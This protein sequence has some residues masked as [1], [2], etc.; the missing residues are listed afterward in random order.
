[1]NE[2][3]NDMIQTIN[4]LKQSIKSLFDD[5]FS[6]DIEKVLNE[7]NEQMDI[8]LSSIEEYKIHFESFKIPQELIDYCLNYGRDIIKPYY[9]R[10]ESLI[11]KETR[12]LTQ[13][14]VEKNSIEFEK[15]FNSYEILN[16]IDKVNS[17]VQMNIDDSFKDIDSYGV[18]NYPNILENEINRIESRN[19]RRLND[20]Q[21]EEDKIEEYREKIADRAI[22]EN[23]NKL[24]GL[25]K[26]TK[27]YIQNYEYFDIFSDNIKNFRK[28]L[29]LSYK[30][31]QQTIHDSFEE[32]IDMQELLNDKLE[33]L[34][35]LSLNYY[36]EIEYSFNSLKNYIQNSL[37]EIDIS[38]NECANITYETFAEKYDSLSKEANPIDKPYDEVIKNIPMKEFY[39]SNQF[40]EFITEATIKALVKKAKFKFQL[41]Y[42]GEEG[43]IKKPKILAIVNNEIKP[44]EIR[45]KVKETFGGCGEEYQKFDIL[46]INKLN[47]TIILTF[48]TESTLVNYTTITDFDKIN[49]QISRYKIEDSETNS[50]VDTLE[51]GLCIKECEDYNITIIDEPKW[52]N[53]DKVNR[54]EPKSLIY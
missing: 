34:Y 38:L 8:T 17:S 19:L 25:S 20:E 35:N 50:C 9:E 31:S 2:Q 10:I 18:K 14:N 27:K 24:L 54:S 46:E 30:E 45:F 52:G 4:E 42:D 1:M 41:I 7:T 44:T 43:Q 16:K 6:L 26:N 39:T 48:D 51:M 28:K 32:E 47:Y 12:S 23:F 11:N 37:K 15:S 40:G 53:F 36:N 49:Y 13:N 29:S 3:T 33:V 21:T 22:D 5:L